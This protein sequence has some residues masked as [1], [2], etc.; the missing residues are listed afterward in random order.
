MPGALIAFL[1]ACLEQANTSSPSSSPF[2]ASPRVSALLAQVGT[3]LPSERRELFHQLAMRYPKETVA[4]DA[5]IADAHV[6]QVPPVRYMGMIVVA[7]SLETSPQLQAVETPGKEDEHLLDSLDEDLS[8]VGDVFGTG[9]ILTVTLRI[10]GQRSIELEAKPSADVRK[11]VAKV[12]G[13]APASVLLGQCDIAQGS[14]AENG[15]EAS[16][17]PPSTPVLIRCGGTLGVS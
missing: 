10:P 7:D 9:D 2:T 16:Y 14:F 5:E 13:F 4:L 1:P 6:P 12:V 8:R 3:I 11:D 15:V 17:A